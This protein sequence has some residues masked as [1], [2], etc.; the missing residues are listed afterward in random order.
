MAQVDLKL[1]KEE[2]ESILLPNIK[3]SFPNLTKIDLSVTEDRQVLVKFDLPIHQVK[4]SQEIL[5]KD[6]KILE[7]RSEGK[8]VREISH[9]VGENLKTVKE[10]LAS[11]EDT[12]VI[13][14]S[15]SEIFKL[16][17]QGM[18]I[19]EIAGKVGLDW[20]LV[21]GKLAAR[22]GQL[23]VTQRKKNDKE[24]MQDLLS[25]LDKKAEKQFSEGKNV[26]DIIEEAIADHPTFRATSIKE[27]II[28][29]FRN[30]TASKP[31]LEDELGDRIM[32]LYSTATVPEIIAIL[33]GEGFVVTAK[34]IGHRVK[35]YQLKEIARKA[36]KS[37]EEKL[38]DRGRDWKQDD[39]LKTDMDLSSRHDL[40]D[41]GSQG[42]EE[43]GVDINTDD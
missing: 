6:N 14:S 26:N 16:Y 1:S 28:K 33:D 20:K 31:S 3:A 21:S 23:A 2:L 9:A 4:P 32:E 40:E 11:K 5:S 41:F 27:R 29:T 42:L 39:D 38:P 37:I 35:A 12:G 7:M 13:V 8:N 22:A 24:E 17:D 15:D 43:D 19:K 34:E 10:V 36:G 25:E 30:R 18:K